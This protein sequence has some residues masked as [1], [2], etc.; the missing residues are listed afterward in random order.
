MG[1][2]SRIAI[3]RRLIPLLIPK[4]MK[5]MKEVHW[6]ATVQ[7]VNRRIESGSDRPDFMSPILEF[8]DEKKG[9]LTLPGVMANMS[10]FII[11]GSESVSMT[12]TGTIFYL[13]R[14]PA[15]MRRL[16]EE[17]ESA[18]ASEEEITPQRL[19]QL[20]CLLACLAETGRIYPVG[21]SGQP[22]VVPPA[23]EWI[24][25]KWV[26]EGVS[27]QFNL[28]SSPCLLCLQITRWIFVVAYEVLDCCYN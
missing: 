12:L 11:A 8:S 15:K 25:G 14:H 24:C 9:G 23:G 27:L 6:A 20:P 16:S 10:L 22:M 2:L 3:L 28:I 7:S 18:F 21:L 26:P 4:R 1:A 5:Q 13:L 17:I 19:S